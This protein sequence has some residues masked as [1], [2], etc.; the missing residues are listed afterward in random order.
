MLNCMLRDI[1]TWNDSKCTLFCWLLLRAINA[2]IVQRMWCSFVGRRCEAFAS[3]FWKKKIYSNMFNDSDALNI[4]AFLSWNPAQVDRES[5][6]GK[7]SH[8]IHLTERQFNVEQ[9]ETQKLIF[10]RIHAFLFSTRLVCFV[11]CVIKVGKLERLLNLF[12]YCC[13]T[14]RLFIQQQPQPATKMSLCVNSYET[15]LLLWFT[16]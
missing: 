3:E 1:H 13:R 7:T 8:K 10:N 4:R 15:L 12:F 6:I 5:F 16:P 11:L 2:N 14:C 9:K